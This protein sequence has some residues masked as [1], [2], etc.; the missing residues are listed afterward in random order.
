MKSMLREDS[1]SGKAILSSGMG[2][3]TVATATKVRLSFPMLTRTNYAAWA[4]R[5][6]FLLRANGA[7]GAVDRG[8]K[9]TSKAV[10]EVEV[11]RIDIGGPE[12]PGPRYNNKSTS[13]QPVTI[14]SF[15]LSP[16]PNDEEENLDILGDDD[17]IVSPNNMTSGHGT[18]VCGFDINLPDHGNMDDE[19]ADVDVND[20]ADEGLNAAD[21]L[22]AQMRVSTYSSYDTPHA[23]PN[24]K[25][26]GSHRQIY[27][28][29]SK[30][31]SPDKNTPNL[32]DKLEEYDNPSILEDIMLARLNSA[33]DPSETSGTMVFNLLHQDNIA[34]SD[35][36]ILQSVASG[37]A[38]QPRGPLL[39]ENMFVAV[40][41]D[42]PPNPRVQGQG[43]RQ[44]QQQ[45]MHN[46]VVQQGEKEG[47]EDVLAEQE[48]EEE[49]GG[50]PVESS[51]MLHL[52]N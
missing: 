11:E 26:R 6:K 15:A 24:L 20:E 33:M 21:A 7:W 43:K 52:K 10:N 50:V 8:K 44:R 17:D 3:S 12:N 45:M 22:R 34:Q 19:I 47:E 13:Y 49:E 2:N 38:L 46:V 1:S 42:N 37:R 31:A 23:D 35:V 16:D 5:M 27:L 25:S 48:A 14:D 30:F 29:E 32:E 40:Q 36:Q 18:S 41:R 9:P 28:K 39:E 51:L 4:M